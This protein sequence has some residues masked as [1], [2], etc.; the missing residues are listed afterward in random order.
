MIKA[1]RETQEKNKYIV[2]L[3]TGLGLVHIVKTCDLKLGHENA[4]KTE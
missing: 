3:F 2:K 4:N 1:I